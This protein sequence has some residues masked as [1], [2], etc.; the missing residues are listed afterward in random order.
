[1]AG[2]K[3]KLRVLYHPPVDDIDQQ[4]IDLNIPRPHQDK[5]Q[6][7]VH[8]VDWTI[9]SHHV[10]NAVSMGVFKNEI[11]IQWLGGWSIALKYTKKIYDVLLSYMTQ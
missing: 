11:H 4:F 3:V 9:N 6:P 1:M 2:V 7:E 5:K 10:Q 8:Y